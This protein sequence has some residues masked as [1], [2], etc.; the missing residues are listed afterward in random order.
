MA[1]AEPYTIEQY[2][3]LKAAI[4]EGTSYVQYS[5]KAIRYRSLAEMRETLA[6][7]AAELF[8]TSPNTGRARRRVGYYDSGK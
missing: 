7:M 4:A 8:P 5:D 2:R 1:A 3:T 6:L